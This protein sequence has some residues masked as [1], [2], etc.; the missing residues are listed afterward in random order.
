MSSYD[1]I[2]LL[3]FAFAAYKG[4]RKGLIRELAGLLG[5]FIALYFAWHW[6]GDFGSFLQKLLS[7]GFPAIPVIS[8]ALLFAVL[9]AG[10][11]LFARFAT[12]LLDMTMVLGLVNRVAGAFV[13]VFQVFLIVLVFTWIADR[14]SLISEKVKKDAFLYPLMAG[15]TPALYHFS[16]I[17]FPKSEE[18]MDSF[19]ENVAKL[20]GLQSEKNLEEESD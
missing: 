2:V 15:A 18:W 14:T 17:F 5:F 4:F 11:S 6:M 19:N 12:K 13:A 20:K 10:F 8:F 3:L 7:G 16:E 1:L 9:V